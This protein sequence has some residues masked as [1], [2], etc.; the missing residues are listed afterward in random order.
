MNWKKQL[1]EIEK[2]FG[3]HKERDWKPAIGLVKQLLAEH[4]ND[5]ELNIRAIYLLL[6]ILLEED[7][8]DEE[9]DPMANFLKKCF[10]ESY[11]KFSENPEYLFFI[12]YFMVLAEWYFGQNDFKLADEMKRKASKLDPDNILYEWSWRFSDNDPLAEYFAEQLLKHDTE[13]IKWLKNKGA[14]GAYILD[15]I[16]RCKV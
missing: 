9:H 1:S 8:P 6:N 16:E 11:Q 5:L 2:D 15:V 12:G 10:D 13:K 3:F 14:P 7:Y 4:P